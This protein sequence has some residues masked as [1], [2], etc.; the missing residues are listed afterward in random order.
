MGNVIGNRGHRGTPRH[1]QAV[2]LK[3]GSDD[4]NSSAAQGTAS[5]TKISAELSRH[6]RQN[7][8]A[9]RRWGGDSRWWVHKVCKIHK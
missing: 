2:R 3:P 5:V 1:A 6:T 4:G 8:E 9:H 7:A